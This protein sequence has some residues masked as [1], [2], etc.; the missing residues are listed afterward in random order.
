MATVK[1][2]RVIIDLET[3]GGPVMV[4]F[5]ERDIKIA[6]YSQVR[7]QQGLPLDECEVTEHYD[8]TDDAVIAARDRIATGD[9]MLDIVELVV[10]QRIQNFQGEVVNTSEHSYDV[11][12]DRITE[13]SKT[14][15]ASQTAFP[16]QAF[17]ANLVPE[18]QYDFGVFIGRFQPF[19]R[20]HLQV[21]LA[22]LQQCRNLVILIGSANRG[23]DTRN[24]FTAKERAAVIAD[25]LEE[26][27]VLEKVSICDLP[28]H[29]YDMQAWIAAVQSAV[30]AETHPDSKIALTGHHRDNSSF[31]L[32][33]FPNWDFITPA[34]DLVEINATAIRTAYFNGDLTQEF[35][36]KLVAGCRSR[37][38]A[39]S[40][41][42]AT[43][44]SGIRSPP[45]SI[46]ERSI[47]SSGAW[48][49][50]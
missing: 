13:W 6:F 1:N 50:S 9:V 10:A 25:S 49:R 22:A 17:G 31:Y 44:T 14:S 37:R 26:A 12:A 46:A 29:P 33:K 8:T 28:D 4:S 11:T 38:F 18:Q 43:A 39:S 5:K 3:E 32:K 34:T 21:A 45:N 40:N 47:A 41:P 27:G 36:P 15:P 30:K 20:G 23:R 48:V 24:P 7:K 35:E 19:H 42:S 16:N 2:N